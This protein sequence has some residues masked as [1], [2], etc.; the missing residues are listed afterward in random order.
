MCY[1]AAL[2][3]LFFVFFYPFP[4]YHL[5]DFLLTNLGAQLLLLF[6]TSQGAGIPSCCLSQ[7]IVTLVQLL[8]NRHAVSVS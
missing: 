8:A 1:C 6:V 5:E 7:K 2:L 3:Q 4:C